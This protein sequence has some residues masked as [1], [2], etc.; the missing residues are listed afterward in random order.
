M[1]PGKYHG[2]PG[3]IL[4]ISV[5]DGK[6]EIKALTVELEAIEKDLIKAPNKGKKV[7]E[8][9]YVE[10]QELKMKEMAETHGSHSIKIRN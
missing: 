7:T 9:E 3:A 2:L 10:I 6:R 5:D 4:M 8:E 1:G